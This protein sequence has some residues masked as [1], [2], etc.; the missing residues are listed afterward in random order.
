MRERSRDGSEG[1][2]AATALLLMALL[3]LV[4]AATASAAG[5]NGLVAR[6]PLRHEPRPAARHPS[7]PAQAPATVMVPAV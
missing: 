4:A 5:P 2:L 1:F 3:M 7:V 6:H